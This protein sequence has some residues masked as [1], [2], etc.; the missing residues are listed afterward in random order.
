MPE[1]SPQDA[2]IYERL[3]DIIVAETA[4]KR[5][6]LSMSSEIDE[7]GIVGFDCDCLLEAI[8]K[9][10]DVDFSSF[11][12]NRYCAPESMFDFTAGSREPLYVEDLFRAAKN[13]VWT[14][15]GPRKE[16]TYEEIRNE[17]I[18]KVGLW[19]IASVCLGIL[20]KRSIFK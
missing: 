12:L 14:D 16:K 7:L 2:E 10:F 6:E 5:S 18:V 1:I 13:K 20:L 9:E 8:Q 15:K 19:S 3:L 11:V 4:C 17:G